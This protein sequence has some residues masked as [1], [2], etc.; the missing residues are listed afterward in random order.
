MSPHQAEERRRWVRLTRICN[1]RCVFCHDCLSHD[2]SRRPV[3]ELEAELRAG[4]AE[5]AARLILSG[6]EPTLHPA[7]L[8]LVAR[9]R[10][11][12]Y[13][14]VQVVSN[15]RMFA[16]PGFAREAAERGLCEATFSIH[17]Q[18]PGLHD[19][20]TGVAGSFAQALA[21]IHNLQRAGLVVN[22]DVVLNAWNLPVLHEIIGFLLARGIR[23]FDLLWLVP[24]GRAWERRRELFVRPED[25]AP[26]LRRTIELAREA[27]AVV[28]T[29]R[30]PAAALEGLEELIQDPHKL[31]DE[32]RGRATELAGWLERDEPMACRDPERCG[33][34]FLGGFCA[35][36][37]RWREQVR[38]GM[39]QGLRL[40]W[41]QRDAPQA[42]RWAA[43]TRRLWLA[44]PSRAAAAAWLAG[45]GRQPEELVL[46]LQAGAER[47]Q[48]GESA[49][50]G[51]PGGIRLVRLASSDP[52]VLEA[53][54]TA[55]T[56]SLEV[57]LD[58]WSAAWVADQAGGLS[59]GPARFLLSLKRFSSREAAREQ[60]CD[61]HLALA[62]LAGSPMRVGDMPWCAS[63]AAQPLAEPGCLSCE[64]LGPDGG[65]DL[66]GLAEHYLREEY[67]LHAARC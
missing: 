28:W 19:R 16:Y 25:A 31:L 59:Q 32:V 34:C 67:G 43:R 38:A 3:E 37:E 5:G 56:P 7:F 61:P 14:W 13:R 2:G 4:L 35:S 66:P 20:L 1:N 65:L 41:A 21:G 45:L 46:E 23:E 54:W 33:V 51:Q 47:E 22:A 15:G 58:R 40:A 52:R 64:A 53:L 60:G 11:L 24:F 6:G 10:A 9:G 55:G 44:A 42:R 30:L 62:P 12:G 29:N 50:A 8:E 63:R 39:L 48:G 17:G 27:G 49:A 26:A 57:I 18:T 36:L